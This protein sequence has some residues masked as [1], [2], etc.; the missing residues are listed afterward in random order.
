MDR[1]RR[2]GLT[3]EGRAIRADRAHLRRHIVLKLAAMGFSLPD[4]TADPDLLDIG[5]DLLARYR[6]QS[7]LLS[8]H[9][10]PADRRIQNFLERLLAPLAPD[11]HVQLNPGGFI[12][13]RWGVA[14]ELSLPMDRDD[15]S[16][17]N[18]RSHRTANG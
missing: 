5:R 18:I 9:L 11:D 14:R 15:Y 3:R 6:E 2:L 16:N 1:E 17:E 12:L 4:R 7:R 8:A 13:D 10:S